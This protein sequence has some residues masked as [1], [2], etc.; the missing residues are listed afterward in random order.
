MPQL[1]LACCCCQLWKLREH[2]TDAEDLGVWFNSNDLDAWTIGGGTLFCDE[3]DSY[4]YTTVFS[5]AKKVS[6]FTIDVSGKAYLGAPGVD[7]AGSPTMFTNPY[8]E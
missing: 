7:M 5:L 3:M 6:T 1:S 2:V 4:I 8:M